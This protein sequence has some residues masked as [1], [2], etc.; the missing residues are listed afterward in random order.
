MELNISDFYE[1]CK[2]LLEKVFRNVDGCKA[3]RKFGCFAICSFY[4]GDLNNPNY[5]IKS[6]YM[7]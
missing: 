3:K 4:L 1:N 6:M 7:R 5:L 2:N